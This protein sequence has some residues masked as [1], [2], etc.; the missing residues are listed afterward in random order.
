MSK[1]IDISG[2]RFGRWKV[3][4]YLGADKKTRHSLWSC[5]CDCG[6]Y[7]AVKSKD[8]RGGHSK[9]C[10]CLAID[11]TRERSQKSDSGLSKLFRQYV[12][13]SKNR[14]LQFELSLDDF[15]K[16][17]QSECHYCGQLPTAISIKLSNAGAYIFNGIDR[18]D[19]SIGYSI[20]NSVPCCQPCNFLK[21]DMNYSEFIRRASAISRTH[22]GMMNRISNCKNPYQGKFKR[23]L[24]ACS[25]G[26]LR[27]PTVAF[28]LSS[29][30]YNF[31]TRS[32]GLDV[33]HALIPIDKVLIEWADEIIVMD[34]YQE[35]ALKRL[36]TKPVL[37]LNIGDNFEYRDKGLMLIIRTKYDNLTKEI[38]NECSDQKS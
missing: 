25:A 1:Q 18:K 4:S 24:I 19:N 32:V 23:V 3:T 33:G 8:L 9:S 27:S 12:S 38:K 37:N 5:I 31:N 6:K 29:P 35:I 17:T 34:E 22:A 26:L 20:E 2:K 14:H 28:V 16:L 7:G 13:S 30:P 15:K 11:S 21:K 10:G 36:T